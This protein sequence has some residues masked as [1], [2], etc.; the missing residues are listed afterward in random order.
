M[1]HHFAILV[2]LMT[3]VTAKEHFLIQV[4]DDLLNQSKQNITSYSNDYQDYSII[5]TGEQPYTPI[6]A[7]WCQNKGGKC[8]SIWWNG[9]GVTWTI[10][11]V[12]NTGACGHCWTD[13]TE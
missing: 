11:D 13:Y 1:L 12:D 9:T 3:Q 7:N 8:C 6:H 5:C 4:D 10:K 2:I